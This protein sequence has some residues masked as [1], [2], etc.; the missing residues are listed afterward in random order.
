MGAVTSLFV[1]KVVATAGDAVDGDALLR[2]IGLDPADD[3][4]VAQMVADT[5]YYDLLERIAAETGG[6]VDLPLRVGAAM[7]C[8]DYGVFGLAWKTAPTLR[9]SFARAERYWRLL[10]TVSVYEVRARDADAWFV[11]HRAGE[12]RLG[13]RMSNEATL[14]SVVSISRQVSPVPFAPLEVHLKHP[15]PATTAHHEAYFGCPVVFESDHDALLVPAEALVRP[16]RLGDHAI[17]RYLLA[18]LDEELGRMR[19]ESSLGDMVRDAISQ[20]LSDGVPRMTEVARRLGVSERTL[21]RRLGE[22]GLTFQKL[23]EE[24]RRELAEA[25]LVQSDYSMAEVAFLT[26]FSE[27]SAFNACVQALGQPDPRCLSRGAQGL[28]TSVP[29]TPPCDIAGQRTGAAG[30]AGAAAAGV[31]IC[32]AQEHDPKSG[33]RFSENCE[34][35]QIDRAF[36]RSSWIGKCSSP[37]ESCDADLA[38]PRHRR[39]RQDRPAHCREPRRQRLRRPPRFPSVRDPVRL[40]GHGDLGSGPRRCRRR[41]CLVF[42]GSRVSGRGRESRG[43]LS[44]REDR[45]GATPR[46]ALWPRRAPRPPR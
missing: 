12:R 22:E 34:S 1:R 17:T 23:A 13:L 19:A 15:P 4:D 14:A 3:A 37:K 36:V 35:K 31:R 10:T 24:A 7:A 25:L 45:R 20:S 41:L 39:H 2:S 32:I 46:A 9:A 29:G 30:Q 16:N 42:S 26:G 43:S 11:L 38:H 44:C 18:H 28:L 40:G 5:A 6:A 21:Q 27:Q 33:N 8:D